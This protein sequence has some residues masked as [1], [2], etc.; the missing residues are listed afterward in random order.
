ML[1]Y[2][3]ASTVKS[4]SC[5]PIP[6]VRAQGLQQLIH[7]KPERG[8]GDRGNQIIIIIIILVKTN[9]AT[10]H[11]NTPLCNLHKRQR[12]VGVCFNNLTY[13][14]G[15]RGVQ[16]CGRGRG[17][18]LQGVEQVRVR[19]V[20]ESVREQSAK[21]VES[22]S[23]YSKTVQEN[24]R[25]HKGTVQQSTRVYQSILEYTSVYIYILYIILE[26]VVGTLA[27]WRTVRLYTTVPLSGTAPRLAP[28]VTTHRVVSHAALPLSVVEP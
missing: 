15:G 26:R 28:L 2:R 3:L 27:P 4:A 21:R 23:V 5:E 16:G 8:A 24:T 10:T 20:R 11:Q 17:G 6:E 22:R 7:N 1:G 18:G 13:T 12:L 25:E 9:S 19:T 14:G